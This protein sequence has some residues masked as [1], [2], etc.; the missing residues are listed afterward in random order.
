MTST[1]RMRTSREKILGAEAG[2]PVLP[3][4][5]V[6]GQVGVVFDSD[7][8]DADAEGDAYLLGFGLRGLAHRGADFDVSAYG[9]LTLSSEEFDGDG[10][11]SRRDATIATIDAGNP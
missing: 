5:D 7:L 11:K 9:L 1:A 3:S 4:I 10:F 8:D 2:F 6:M